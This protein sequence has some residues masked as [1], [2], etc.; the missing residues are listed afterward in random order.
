MAKKR[1]ESLYKISF[2]L[3]MSMVAM[4]GLT[5]AAITFGTW[6][7]PLHG[8]DALTVGHVNDFYSILQTLLSI[9]TVSDTNLAIGT[10]TVSP[11]LKLDVEGNVGAT[12]YCDQNGA[13]CFTYQ[14]LVEDF[15]VPCDLDGTFVLETER[16]NLGTCYTCC[17]G[18][19]CTADGYSYTQCQN[20][21][22]R[23]FLITCDG[24]RL[25]SITFTD[26]SAATCGCPS[27]ASCGYISYSY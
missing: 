6:E 11:N 8:G 12:M 7:R 24:I 2:I 20:T 19:D 17:G 13:N 21:R 26:W 22:S 14:D 5:F 15:F 3:L 1:L 27:P 10:T 16:E 4:A 18:Q 25:V 23:Q 9:I